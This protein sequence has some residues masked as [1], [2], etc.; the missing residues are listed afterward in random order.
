[1]K[2]AIFRGCGP[3][4]AG[5]TPGL[6]R[7]SGWSGHGDRSPSVFG[8]LSTPGRKIGPRL[9]APR[10]SIGLRDRLSDCKSVWDAQ[11]MGNT[12]L[13]CPNS[14]CARLLPGASGARGVGEEQYCITYYL[15]WFCIPGQGSSPVP[16]A[17]LFGCDCRAPFT[18]NL[19]ERRIRVGGRL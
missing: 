3:L 11:K 8:C 9:G 4:K 10:Q 5:L 17:G 14:P 13:L 12:V 6:I 15:F 18:N 19:W 7:P 1:M 2:S 16:D